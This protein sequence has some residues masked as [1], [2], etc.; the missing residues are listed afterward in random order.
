[1]TDKPPP[2]RKESDR[3]IRIDRS[4]LPPISRPA[5][6]AIGLDPDHPESERMIAAD[7][8]EDDV[9]TLSP[10]PACVKPCAVC[11]STRLVTRDAAA[12]Y[13]ATKAAIEKLS[14]PDDEP[15]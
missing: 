8:D 14:E 1:M 7:L 11:N 15:A 9:P 6:D 5:L 3:T 4:L 2:K 10:C 12:K 13:D